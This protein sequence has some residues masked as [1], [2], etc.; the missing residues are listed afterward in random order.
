MKLG[1]MVTKELADKIDRCCSR[2][3]VDREGCEGKKLFCAEVIAA[4]LD[5][6]EPVCRG[7]KAL[8]GVGE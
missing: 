4:I 1:A 7:A 3:C 2:E 5:D 6:G 8:E